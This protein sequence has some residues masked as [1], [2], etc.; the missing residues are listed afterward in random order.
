MPIVK[1]GKLQKER[2]KVKTPDEVK[3]IEKAV[4]G[5]RGSCHDVYDFLRDFFG[6]HS[7][8]PSS[9]LANIKLGYSSVRVEAWRKLEEYAATLESK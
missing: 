6:I 2:F 7:S 4:E 8:T 3:K 1:V 9:S 5:Y